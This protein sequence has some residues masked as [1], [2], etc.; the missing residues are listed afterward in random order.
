VESVAVR[1]IL[2]VVGALFFVTGIWALA[3]PSSFY[4]VL[5]TWPP[6]NEHLLHDV[7]AF[8]IGLGVTLFAALVWTDAVVVALAG[9]GAGAVAHTLSHLVDAGEGGRAS[10]PFSLGLVALLLVAGIF[11][12]LRRPQTV[13]SPAGRLARGR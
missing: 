4:D 13:D 1:W 5:A 7:G 10:D 12:R 3:V 8:Q 6:Y 11:L 2:W 9:T